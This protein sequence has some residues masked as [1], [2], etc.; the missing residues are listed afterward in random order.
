MTGLFFDDQTE[1]SLAEGL[2][3]F[4]DWLP[5]F[6]TDDA[7]SG[8]KRFSGPRFDSE[9]LAAV[10]GMAGGHPGVARRLAQAQGEVA[11]SMVDG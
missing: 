6:R 8:A 2:A 1:Q 3:R 10:A 7:I 4:E 9:Y 5:S 11:S